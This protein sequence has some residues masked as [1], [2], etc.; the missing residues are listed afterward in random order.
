MD[1]RQN[2]ITSS[3]LMG[4]LIS[5]QLGTVTLSLPAYLAITSGHDGW[6]SILLFGIIITGLIA[7]V[8]KLMNK[9]GNKSIYEINTFLY[10]KYLGGLLNLLIVLYLWYSACLYLRSYTNILHVHLLRLTPNLVLCIFVLI[11]TYYLVW[12]GLKYV[13]RYT[14]MIYISLFICCVLFLL[15]FKALRLTFIMPIGESGVEGIKAS[16]SPCIY[17]FLG[18]EVISVVYPEITNKQK[19]MKYSLCS[20]IITTIFFTILVLVTTSFF[21]EELLKKC[22]Y[23]LV[24]LSSSYRAPVLE[25][26]DLIFV[27][28]WIPAMAMATRGYFCIAYY[29]LHKLL[30]LKKK[31]IYLIVFTAITILLS[32][33]PK[34]NSQL[35]I[36]NNVMVIWGTAFSIFLTICYLFSFIRKKEA[37]PSE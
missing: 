24:E 31:A 11:P 28:F 7:L 2:Q 14:F 3:Q 18:Y 15:V 5:I 35:D 22:M 20:N 12:Y 34:S 36:H 16:F 13:A 26:I 19:A 23:P 29:S 9:Y 17:A 8:I 21:G 6:I 10:G 27:A 33:L 30:N 37:K 32:N 4:L 25:R 1:N